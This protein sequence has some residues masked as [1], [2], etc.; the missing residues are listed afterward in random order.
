MQLSKVVEILQQIAPTAMAEPWD[1]V[2][3]L[4]GDPNQDITGLLLTIDLTAEVAAEAQQ[5]KCDLV[6]AYHPPIF[7]PLKKIIAGSLVFDAIQKG[8]AIYSPHTALDAANGGTNDVLADAIGLTDIRPLRTSKSES[9]Q[10]KLV[11]FV[12]TEHLERVSKALFEAGAGN[13][14]KYSSCSF[15]TPGIGTFFGEAGSNPT[16]GKSGRLEEAQEVRLETVLPLQKVSDVVRALRAAH[17]YE[18]PAFDLNILA[19]DPTGRGMGRFGSLPHTQR[20]EIFARIKKELNLNHLL[21]AGP[22]TGVITKAAVCAGSCG[23]LLDTAIAS[24]AELYLTGEMRHHDAIKAAATGI[25]VVCTLH[26]NSERAVLR[27]LKNRLEQTGGVPTISISATDR[28]P[29][30]ML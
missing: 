14:G 22:T 7:S 16:I 10:C 12:P 5:K 17:P 27:R 20:T 18:E 2:G 23:D 1:N 29:F 9:S 19:P 15:R 25:T 13:I 6:I 24:G 21:I 4:V 28:D 11:T 30:S 26:S 3:L 8:V